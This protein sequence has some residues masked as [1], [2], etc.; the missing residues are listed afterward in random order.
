M[1]RSFTTSNDVNHPTA[2]LP[3]GETVCWARPGSEGPPDRAQH[4]GESLSRP[5]VANACLSE[6]LNTY[7]LAADRRQ[8]R[9]HTLVQPVRVAASLEDR[10]RRAPVAHFGCFD[11]TQ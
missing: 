8:Y 11:E 6:L 3:H 5:L 10:P 7:A 9:L 2:L 1:C 4:V